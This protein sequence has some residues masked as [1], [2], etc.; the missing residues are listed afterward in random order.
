MG[1]SPKPASIDGVDLRFR[2]KIDRVDLTA[3]GKSV[4][5][6]DY[7][8]GGSSYYKNLNKDSID[9]GKR[10]QLGVY[11]LAVRGLYPN[12]E[13]VL[14]QFWFPTTKGEFTLIPS[15]PFNID[16]PQTR[17]RFK[18]G[19]SLIADG[20]KGGVFPANPGPP[21]RDGPSNCT[22]CDFN[23]ICPSRRVDMWDRK[24]KS[25]VVTGYLRLTGEVEEEPEDGE[26]GDA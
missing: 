20:I 1:K 6:F 15:N 19:L 17:N 26:G 22:F 4:F 7:K 9:A 21:G 24:K 23:T 25:S 18:E 2:G 8:T 10:L 12:A 16:D 11:S 13:R 5:V 14:A 3:D